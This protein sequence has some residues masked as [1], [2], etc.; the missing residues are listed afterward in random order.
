MDLT[1]YRP[2]LEQLIPLVKRPDFDETF[3]KLTHAEAGGTRFLLKMEVKR[4]TAPC[5]RIIDLRDRLDGACFIYKDKDITHYF[6]D[7]AR[8]AYE[9]ALT[10]YGEYTMGV[11]EAVMAASRQQEGEQAI[12]VP[13]ALANE[14]RQRSYEAELIHF[15][16]RFNRN[17]ERLQLTLPIRI[18]MPQGGR[19]PA[20]TS[21]ISED[22]LR[23]RMSNFLQM[24]VGEYVE[25]NL[26]ALRKRLTNPPVIR[27][28]ARYKVV[29]IYRKNENF[30]WVGLTYADESPALSECI[31]ELISKTHARYRINTEYVYKSARIH[32]FEN[33]YLLN[34]AVLPV[35]MTQ[36][37]PGSALLNRVNQTIWNYWQDFDKQSYLGRMLT[38]ER[39][40]QLKQQPNKTLLLISFTFASEDELYFYEATFVEL[41]NSGLLQLML[42]YASKRESF[43]IFQL[44]WIE[45]DM[46]HAIRPTPLPEQRVNRTE[47][48]SPPLQTWLSSLQGTVLIEDVTPTTEQ[49]RYQHWPLPIEKANELQQLLQSGNFPATQE[50]W[51]K[52]INQRKEE[53]YLLRLDVEIIIGQQKIKGKTRNVST[54]GLQVELDEPLNIR[55]HQKV[56]I[57][58]VSLKAKR[59]R[60]P[61]HA[62]CYRI[63]T[64]TGNHKLVNLQFLSSENKSTVSEYLQTLLK[65]NARRLKTASEARRLPEQTEAL[66]NI[67]ACQLPSLPI[68]IT[69]RRLRWLL[70]WVGLSAPGARLTRL[71]ES[72]AQAHHHKVPL[73]H[74]SRIDMMPLFG[75]EQGYQQL[76]REL[77]QHQHADTPLIMECMVSN[78]PVREDQFSQIKC[79]PLTP[80]LSNEHVT[81]FIEQAQ[82][83]GEFLG[84]RLAIIKPQP[85]ALNIVQR[86]LQYLQQKAIHQAQDLEKE[87]W[88]LV[89]VGDITDITDELLLRF[90]WFN[91]SQP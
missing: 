85:P 44:R 13:A 16:K 41:Q 3:R 38:A 45:L 20:I 82:R 8:E 36:Q 65:Q 55:Y 76:M 74:L 48:L 79:I 42:S 84:I 21:D 12:A 40:S 37:G 78:P 9:K 43:R 50:V 24:P 27:W 88:S 60:L 35:F 1:H 49:N 47:Q 28:K 23:I 31:Q 26:Q 72:L 11:Y 10:L 69:K 54:Q 4:L 39:L 71:L 17:S 34:T 22:G 59:P 30:Q 57:H 53:R 58:F 75:G 90:G 19:L 89:G 87:L 73:H 51:F 56:H 7:T 5:R 6:D 63:K 86:E 25:I 29:E 46:R 91:A 67:Y 33:T 81:E 83:E 61:L 2:L 14:Q 80:E 52:Y 68:F 18:H 15:T 64:L 70:S 77:R 66:R 62:V 32:S